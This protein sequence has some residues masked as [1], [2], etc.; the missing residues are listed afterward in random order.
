MPTDTLEQPGAGEFVRP[1]QVMALAH[2]TFT[3]AELCKAFD[4]EK[5]HIIAAVTRLG[6]FLVS[7]KI[8]PAGRSPRQFHLLDAYALLIYLNFDK[9]FGA[10]GRKTLVSEV[11]HL[12]FGDF[13]SESEAAA[14]PAE[15]AA[16][17]PGKREKFMFRLHQQRRAE[18]RSDMFAASP[19]W[20][21][22]DA[23]RRFVLFGC[24]NHTILS[25]L[26]D[27]RINGGK[28]D[29]APLEKVG[30]GTWVNCTELFCGAD[31]TLTA[32]VDA[33]RRGR[34]K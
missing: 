1:P 20:W 7:D 30:V 11:S 24:R 5:G 2:E 28:V 8:G 22:R 18:I 16:M 34:L 23:D 25:G 3:Q 6:M 32:I 21:S 26:F 9:H 15:V 29:L 31:A 13:V 17:P 4:V 19:L 10:A 12:L 33:T 14:R 27:R